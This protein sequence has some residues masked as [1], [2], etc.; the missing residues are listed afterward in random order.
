MPPDLPPNLP[1]DLTRDLPLDLPPPGPN[2]GP[3]TGP[4]TRHTSPLPPLRPLPIATAQSLV[5]HSHWLS[6]RWSQHPQWRGLW[7]RRWRW[8]RGRLRGGKIFVVVVMGWPHPSLSPLLSTLTSPARDR[9]HLARHCNV[10]QCCHRC[11]QRRQMRWGV[12]W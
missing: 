8:W 9:G 6:Q 1:P 12:G 5:A 2:T 11:Q 4:P 7:R 3:P 10:I